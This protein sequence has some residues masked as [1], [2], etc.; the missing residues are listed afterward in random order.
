MANTTLIFSG[1]LPPNDATL[2]ATRKIQNVNLVIAADSGLHTA[3]RLDVHVD[4]VIGDFDSV[5]ATALARATSAHTQT[6]RHSADKDFTD[7]ESA[8][9]FAADKKSERIVIVT[10]GGGRLDHQF[11]VVAAMFNPKLHE[12]NVEALWNDAHLFAL[13][14]PTTREFAVEIGDTIGL[15]SFS[16]KSEKISTT[17]LRWQLNDATLANFE[18]R[19]V[20]N[21][22]IT[23][24]VS[25]TVKTGQLIVTH[26]RQKKS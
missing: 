7:L 19:G 12:T 5:D 1:G 3:Q 4:V 21:I 18:T 26:Q 10:A 24:Q 25:V 20:G 23:E 6:I 16:N 14:G 11:G 17:G 2:D 15:Q 13:Q 22:A 8:L 9:L